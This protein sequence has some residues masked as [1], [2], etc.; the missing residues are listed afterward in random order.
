MTFT[1]DYSLR[2]NAILARWRVKKK[3]INISNPKSMRIRH[4]KNAAIVNKPQRSLTDVRK[5][6]TKAS[7]KE[8]TE[9]IS[10]EILGDI[11][12]SEAANENSNNE[13]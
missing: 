12:L 10:K 7:G 4:Y 8:D 3:C 1:F 11:D 5:E 2:I 13:K 6:L 9:A